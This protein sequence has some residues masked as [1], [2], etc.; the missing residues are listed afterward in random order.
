MHQQAAVRG[1]DLKIFERV[2]QHI[3]RRG[4]IKLLDIAQCNPK[5]DQDQ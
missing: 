4:K 2:M 1:I 3:Q 5:Y